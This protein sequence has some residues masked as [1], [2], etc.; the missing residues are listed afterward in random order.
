MPGPD[1]REVLVQWLDWQRATVVAKCAGLDPTRADVALL[2]TSPQ[3][4]ISG[5]VSHLTDV[6]R[7]WMVRSFLGQ[8]TPE[9]RGGGWIPAPGR[10]LVLLVQDHRNQC[11]RS[12]E[13]AAAHHLDALEGWAPPGLPRVTLR[14]ILGHL[15]HETARH[16]GHLDLLRENADGQRGY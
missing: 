8:S 10:S 13:V 2:P 11:D 14:W 16:L 3:L 15:V 6:E 7:H 9:T 4:T 5:V 12:R 1:E